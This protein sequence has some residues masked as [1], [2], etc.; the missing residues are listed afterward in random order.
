MEKLFYREVIQLY[1]EAYT[2]GIV[3][4]LIIKELNQKHWENIFNFII[5]STENSS[6]YTAKNELITN[7]SLL[8][9]SNCSYFTYEINHMKNNVFIEEI[10]YLV[11]NFMPPET[12]E[13]F[14][15]ILLFYKKLG[16]YINKNFIICTDNATYP[17]YVKYD[18]ELNY[19]IYVET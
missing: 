4:D 16:Y 19:Y 18:F 8:N 6:F 9:T 10:D 7:N 5:Q 15:E 12:F 1:E 2:D 17:P 3:F 14:N 11:I 13:K